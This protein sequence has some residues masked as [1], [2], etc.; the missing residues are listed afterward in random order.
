MFLVIRD[1]YNIRN[2][3]LNKLELIDKNN[4]ESSK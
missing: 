3:T 2:N 4:K 1:K